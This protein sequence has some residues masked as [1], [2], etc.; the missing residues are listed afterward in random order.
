MFIYIDIYIVMSPFKQIK[1]STG[2]QPKS[3]HS[4]SL[5]RTLTL[6]M[7]IAFHLGSQKIEELSQVIKSSP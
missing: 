6:A 5:L 3:V 4:G 7:F 1:D 2:S